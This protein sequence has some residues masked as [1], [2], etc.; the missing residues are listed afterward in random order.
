MPASDTDP[1]D[2]DAAGRAPG[3][4]RR[5]TLIGVAK[6]ALAIGILGVLVYRLRGE[7]VFQRLLYEPKHWGYLAGAQALVCTAI[8]INY[9]RWYVLVRALGLN[10]RVAD[11]F[12]LG[13]IG[14]LINQVLPAGSVGGDLFKALFIAREQPGRRTE[15]VA[16][17]VIDRV[18][19]LYGMM[20]VASAG[21]L[22]GATAGELGRPV[23]LL[24]RTVVV[25]AIVG[26]LGITVLLSP[27]LAS[28]RVRGSLARVPAAGATLLRLADAAGAYRHRVRYLAGAVVL[29]CCTHTLFVT[30]F[31]CIGRGLPVTAPEMAT[32]YVIGPLSM[33][34]GALPVTPGGLGVFEAALD[35]L[36]IYVGAP[37]GDGLFVALT[38][39]VTTYVMAAIGA[40]YYITARRSIEGPSREI[41]IS[42]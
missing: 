24:G 37:P 32:M 23:E 11:A 6:A 8:T 33:A 17:V 4:N 13:S 29:A 42:D 31:W 2:V 9:L 19:G 35:K 18:V 34:A 21:Y 7:D 16:S 25:A 26:G 30:S 15:A 38:Y 5:R 28:D 41:A 20:L 12:R 1:I 39:R 3:A 36:Y 10:F 27:L 40:I 22:L 14:M